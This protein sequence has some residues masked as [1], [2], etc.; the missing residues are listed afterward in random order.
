MVC[1]ES[2]D[3]KNPPMG[4]C[5]IKMRHFELQSRPIRGFCRGTY[6]ALEKVGSSSYFHT[7]SKCVEMVSSW[8]ASSSTRSGG[9]GQEVLMVAVR[10]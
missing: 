10:E 5:T 6:G 7:A 1:E 3:L 4:I 2:C 9:G 8:R